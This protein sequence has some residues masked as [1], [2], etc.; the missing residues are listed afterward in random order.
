[1]LISGTGNS[2]FFA[3][4]PNSRVLTITAGH[5]MSAR[6]NKGKMKLFCFCQNLTC[7]AIDHKVHAIK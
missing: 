4:N 2:V 5:A 7:T 3:S 6:K 1:M